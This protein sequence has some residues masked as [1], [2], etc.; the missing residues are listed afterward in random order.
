MKYKIPKHHISALS[1]YCPYFDLLSKDFFENEEIGE[2]FDETLIQNKDGSI[3]VSFEFFPPITNNSES[4]D[5]DKTESMSEIL[6]SFSKE[7]TVHFE[8]VANDSEK[9]Y[10]MATL[11]DMPP[12]SKMIEEKR[13]EEADSYTIFRLRYFIT[14]NFNFLSKAKNKKKHIDETEDPIEKFYSTIKNFMAMCE[15]RDFRLVLLKGDAL[16]TYLHSCL[17]LKYN[18]ISTSIEK[19]YLDE[20]LCTEPLDYMKFPLRLG[21]KYVC[22]FSLDKIIGQYSFANNLAPLFSLGIPLRL[23][24]RFKCYSIKESEKVIEKK[25]EVYNSKIFDLG[26]LIANGIG[27]GNNQSDPNIRELN[28]KSET[29]EALE[30][31]TSDRV[32]YGL[33]TGVIITYSNDEA[34]LKR[35]IRAIEDTFVSL[36]LNYKLERLNAF[37]ALVSSLPGETHSNPREF[38]LSTNNMA[39]YMQLCSLYRGNSHNPFMKKITGSDIPLLYGYLRNGSPF[40]L[41][42][43]G[44]AEGSEEDV[45]HT[46]I[47]G[48]PGSGKS[49]LLSLLASSYMKYPHT[50][51]IIFD[52]GLSA[53]ALTKANNGKIIIPLKD[54]VVFNPL[55]NV[56]ENN[57]TALHFLNTLLDV[58]DV[59]TTPEEKKDISECLDYL[60]SEHINLSSFK[61]TLQ[62]RNHNH[63]L[64]Y[65]LEKYTNG[66]YGALFNNTEDLFLSDKNERLTLVEL[67][68]L[69]NM[70][71]DMLSPA[72][73]YMFDRLNELFEDRVPTLLI[74]DE[75]W[76]FLMNDLFRNYL[77]TLLKTMRKHNVFVV[78]ATQSIADIEENN[79]TESTILSSVHTRIFLPEKNL[80]S[81]ELLY[82]LYS[83]LGLS[84]Y[85]KNIISTSMQYKRD[86]YIIQKGEGEALV[87]FRASSLIPY[88][89]N[90]TPNMEKLV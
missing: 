29:E 34:I 41:N 77:V 71:N 83:K 62:G 66:S 84:T 69:M 57:A 44:T 52:K 56:K 54:N 64:V 73:I 5:S 61:T 80:Q 88:F 81:D 45:G 18:K 4:F 86:Y 6:S 46:L 17:T 24:S 59:K 82:N 48:S 35:Y 25:R 33:Y 21:D 90:Y 28:N 38:L 10:E 43:N 12:L 2:F 53:Y 19:T 9:W 65:I 70:G 89:K 15:S 67:G 79:R 22:V 30:T 37:S 27:G 39:S 55:R 36:S 11:D 3:Q 16:L 32:S 87:D 26:K 7:Y 40:Y 78:M 72:L 63:P 58:N 23:V 1:E 14:I 47:V 75:C 50:R 8:E 85:Q 31:L 68:E 42:L 74:L 13:K 49:F 20:F 51:C 60:T 76:T